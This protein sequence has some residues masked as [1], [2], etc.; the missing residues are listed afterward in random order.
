MP[1]FLKYHTPASPPPPLLLPPVT[2]ADAAAWR[3]QE[4]DKKAAKAAASRDYAAAL[5]LQLKAREQRAVTDDVG[6]SLAE[7]QINSR[8]LAVANTIEAGALALTC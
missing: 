5:S 8:L 1:A 3:A 2:Q 7:A 4:A 6:M